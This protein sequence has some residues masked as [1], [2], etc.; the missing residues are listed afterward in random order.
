MYFEK[1]CERRH[2][3]AFALELMKDAVNLRME[4][5]KSKEKH[6]HVAYV[7]H[8]RFLSPSQKAEVTDKVTQIIPMPDK[9]NKIFVKPKPKNAE[10]TKQIMNSDR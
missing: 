2:Y 10:P 7:K 3:C 4:R 8:N 6:Y 1:N 5:N 9:I